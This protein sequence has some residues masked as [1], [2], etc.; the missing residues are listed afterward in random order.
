MSADTTGG[1][2][3]DE[4]VED[5]AATFGFHLED[6]PAF[7]LDLFVAGH[8]P[9]LRAQLTERC[10]D[11][12]A[13]R[14]V[15][16]SGRPA[17]AVDGELRR[18]GSY[19]VL[20]SL[21]RGSMAQV[22]LARDD[23]NGREVALKVLRL[24]SGLISRAHE[25]FRREAAMLSKLRHPAIATVHEVGE[26]DG[27][28]FIAMDHVPGRTLSSLL[29]EERE[30][31]FGSDLPADTVLEGV[32]CARAARL[33][34]DLAD[35]LHAAHSHQ[36]IHRDLKPENIMVDD[37]GRPHLLDF[38][39][40]RD[41]AEA[42]I[43]AEGDL[44]GTPYYMSPEQVLGE[45]RTLTPA[46]DVFVLG[47][48]LYELLTLR[49]PFTGRRFDQVLEAI[50][51]ANPLPVRRLHPD[52]PSDL[53]AI[54]HRALARDPADRYETAAGLAED[55][56]RFLDHRSVTATRLALPAGSAPTTSTPR[57]A[58]RRASPSRWLALILVL[59]LL[60]VA[61]QWASARRDAA[62]LSVDLAA[63]DTLADPDALRRLAQA[64]ARA[65]TLRLADVPLDAE[66]EARV[67]AVLRAAETLGRRELAAALAELRR[68]GTHV[69]EALLR[70]RRLLAA[71]LLLPDDPQMIDLLQ[72]SGWWPTLE[73]S[74]PLPGTLVALRR[75]DALLLTPMGPWETEEATP[76]GPFLLSP[77]AYLLVARAGQHRRA[78]TLLEVKRPLFAYDLQLLPVEAGVDDSGMQLLEAVAF[79]YDPG[80]A[81]SSDSAS[82]GAGQR[83]ALPAFRID[84]APVSRAD[85]EA[86]LSA[87]GR[88]AP[89]D[90]HEAG[91]Q[92][93]SAATGVSHGEALAYAS[94]RGRRLPSA[95]E[96]ERALGMPSAPLGPVAGL[97]EWT[98]SPAGS[99]AAPDDGSGPSWR[100]VRGADS[101]GTWRS[102]AED[103]RAPDLGFRCVLSLP[104]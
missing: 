99:P 100:I 8:P 49:R 76:V 48:L 47:V 46:A 104:R 54:C 91:S 79:N 50:A 15:L 82:A 77:G 57:R 16:A 3:H 55:L 38:G 23:R 73:V 69:S 95:A 10:R 51:A 43:S 75:L 42:S 53:E 72:E 93:L 65:R 92:P 85:F 28:L 34:A 101:G 71:A 35:A 52:V 60:G 21:G 94:W 37:D 58:A 33:V 18:L 31:R 74:S 26:V 7:D 45:R 39:L 9:E 25:R 83:L 81:P 98:A 102:C 30:R 17:P 29:K 66:S 14:Q 96:W 103:Q 68:S 1:D 19:R 87:T 61:L 67:E 86:F 2:K 40:A 12:A 6:D 32:D 63:P 64:A 4:R 56:L 89:P 24:P 80:Q 84:S 44:A 78:E 97:R 20:R 62:R 13:L 5:L 11:V 70:D 22:Y 27:K 36:V 88:P 41:M 59:L 90:W